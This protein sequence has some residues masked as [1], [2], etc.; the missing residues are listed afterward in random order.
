VAFVTSQ[1]FRS[2]IYFVLFA[3]PT[4][5]SAPQ[6]WL[7]NA[8]LILCISV[9]VSQTAAFACHLVLLSFAGEPSGRCGGGIARMKTFVDKQRAED[10]DLLLLNA[11][12]DFIGTQWDREYGSKAAAFFLNK[13]A[14][15]AMVRIG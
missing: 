4:N 10:P 11:G 2:D 15:D 12:D 13:L 7:R 3:H 8:L 5:R 14:P 6:L 1:N 9:P